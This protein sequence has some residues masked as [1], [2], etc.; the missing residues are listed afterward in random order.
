[1]AE[2]L[3]RAGRALD[4]LLFPRAATCM[5]CG[6]K[7]GCAHDWLCDE[8]E[9]AL[10]GLWLGDGPL[11][12]VAPLAGFAAAYAYRDP[13]AALVRSLKYGAVGLLAG[14]MAADMARA[15]AS[16]PLPPHPL[17]VPS[18][19]FPWRE[20]KRGYNQAELLAKPI[21]AAFG[22][23]CR[24][25]MRK[26]PFTPTQSEQKDFAARQKNAARALLPLENVD[27]SGPSVVLVDDII[28]T[29]S[30]AAAAA[31]VLRKMGAA[32]VY[33][34]APARTPRK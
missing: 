34:L 22:L 20:R 21:A 33:V 27:L 18:P 26:R 9:R 14:P 16:L 17:V 11:P 3:R 31:D 10:A 30:T 29:G 32:R 6:D 28:T 23:P 12:C 5:G 15:C 4:R 19:M 7:S 8:C 2:L 25:T 13:A 24:A 1:M